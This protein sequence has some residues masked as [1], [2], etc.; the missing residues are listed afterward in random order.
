MVSQTPDGTMA[1]GEAGPLLIP[2]AAG[3]LPIEDA[4]VG[5]GIMEE[6]LP[7]DD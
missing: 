3:G 4:T 5:S 6:D 1:R 7:L 2:P